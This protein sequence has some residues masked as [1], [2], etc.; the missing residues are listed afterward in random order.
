[1]CAP[2]ARV[3]RRDTLWNDN[4]VQWPLARAGRANPSI[5]RLGLHRRVVVGDRWHRR[6]H[7]L[8][9]RL[10][11]GTIAP[12][13]Y[14]HNPRIHP[15]PSHVGSE[16]SR[17]GRGRPWASGHR[18]RRVQQH[19]RRAVERHPLRGTF[20]RV[21]DI[22]RFLNSAL[23]GD[24]VVQDYDTFAVDGFRLGRVPEVSPTFSSPASAGYVAS[25]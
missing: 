7:P 2:R 24:R 3:R 18:Y 23:A 13:R 1:M 16:R 5:G 25:R 9:T 22:V 17:T 8:G 20:W 14:G 10:C 12:A 11:V 19:H 6:L 4:P 21:R 15:G